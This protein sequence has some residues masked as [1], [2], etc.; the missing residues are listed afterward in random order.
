MEQLDIII[1]LVFSLV[2]ILFLELLTDKPMKQEVYTDYEIKEFAPVE[3]SKPEAPTGHVLYDWVFHYNP[4]RAMWFAIPRD[5]YNDYWSNIKDKRVLK[6]RHLNHLLDL[7]QRAAGD[8]EM[9]REIASD[10]IK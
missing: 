3:E 9:I 1:G 7:L 10:D 6:H 2:F 4:H 8:V 5:A